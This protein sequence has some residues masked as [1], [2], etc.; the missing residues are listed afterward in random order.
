[1]SQLFKYQILSY[2]DGRYHTGEIWAKDKATAI[3]L[4]KA[5]VKRKSSR[6]ILL[7]TLLLSREDRV[8]S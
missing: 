7:I 6:R 1:M 8:G 5:L 3:N 2:Y 4:I